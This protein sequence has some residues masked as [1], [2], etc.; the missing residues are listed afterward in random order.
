MMDSGFAIMAIQKAMAGTAPI[1]SK[2]TSPEVISQQQEAFKWAVIELVLACLATTDFMYMDYSVNIL[3]PYS[4]LIPTLKDFKRE[5]FARE[6]YT[7]LATAKF[8]FSKYLPRE[9]AK[10]D[11][12]Q[13]ARAFERILQPLSLQ[14]RR[15]L[16]DYGYYE[17]AIAKFVTAIG[18]GQDKTIKAAP[19]ELRMD[20]NVQELAKS[21]TFTEAA[22]EGHDPSLVKE[23]LEFT[24]LKQV[25]QRFTDALTRTRLVWLDWAAFRSLC[26]HYRIKDTVGHVK[27]AIA[28]LALKPVLKT[29]V[30][31]FTAKDSNSN[32]FRVHPELHTA[33]GLGQRISALTSELDYKIS[34]NNLAAIAAQSLQQVSTHFKTAQ[35]VSIG[36]SPRLLRY[37]T[38]AISEVQYYLDQTNAS[39]RKTSELRSGMR[40]QEVYTVNRHDSIIVGH[41]ELSK[42]RLAYSFI[43]PYVALLM[44][45]DNELVLGQTKSGAPN[46]DK[47]FKLGMPMAPAIDSYLKK[48]K[49]WLQFPSTKFDSYR[50]EYTTDLKGQINS[51]TVKLTMENIFGTPDSGELYPWVNPSVALIFAAVMDGVRQVWT[52]IEE[53][54]EKDPTILMVSRRPLAQ[55]LVDITRSVLNTP[56]GTAIYANLKR[57]IRTSGRFADLNYSE[58][59]HATSSDRFEMS[60]AI[61]FAFTVLNY[62]GILEAKDKRLINKIFEDSEYFH[63]SSVSS[64]LKQSY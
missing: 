56:E 63:Y 50:L 44:N 24:I 5:V 1:P 28:V 34:T 22:I 3:L 36:M 27:G 41:D 46:M 53:S 12:T 4:N 38:I 47:L 59:L 39:G 54:G 35:V 62:L 15:V 52:M 11:T 13:L 58:T 64:I 2:G 19:I 20:A 18:G 31:E 48:E 10:W 25:Y 29:E 49:N 57:V 14:F 16:T 17:M 51:E 45:E 40:L 60:V 9:S 32:I 6:I 33:P 43:D 7:Q 61:G 21:L 37:Y 42:L 8:D 26:G 30:R 23:A 55:Y